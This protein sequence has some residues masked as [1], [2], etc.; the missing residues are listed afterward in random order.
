MNELPPATLQDPDILRI[1]RATELI[2]GVEY[3]DAPRAAMPTY[4]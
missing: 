2:G 4:R 1:S 3:A